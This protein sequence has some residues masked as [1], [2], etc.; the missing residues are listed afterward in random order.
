VIGPPTTTPTPTATTTPVVITAPTSTPT[1]T[2]VVIT[3]PTSTP[4]PT[5]TPAATATPTPT[6]TPTPAATA[7][8]TP[9]PTP[10]SKR[11]RSRGRHPRRGRPTGR[12]PSRP[13]A[14][15]WLPSHP[16]REGDLRHAHPV[17]RRDRT[18]DSG[19]FRAPSPTPAGVKR[20]GTRSGPDFRCASHRSGERGA[21]IVSYPDRPSGARPSDGS[22]TFLVVVPPQT[23]GVA[24]ETPPAE[25]AVDLGEV[26]A[27][28][29]RVRATSGVS[30]LSTAT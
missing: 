28:V 2:P 22:G 17:A 18:D 26:R 16:V 29:A 30:W 3:A 5:P 9:T 6:P 23:G 11:H 21:P 8:P 25:E 24:P 19:T 15:G 27:A 1:P 4:T 20:S 10:T 13:R 14:S 7:T 12:R